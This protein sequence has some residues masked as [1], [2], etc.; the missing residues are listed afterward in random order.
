MGIGPSSNAPFGLGI[1][2][3]SSSSMDSS[4]TCGKITLIY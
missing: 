1:G 3:I 2:T 4:P